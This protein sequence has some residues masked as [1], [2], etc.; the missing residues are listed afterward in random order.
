MVGKCRTRVG[1]SLSQIAEVDAALSARAHRLRVQQ[2]RRGTHRRAR[3]HNAQD[4]HNGD[5]PWLRARRRHRPRQDPARMGTT[6]LRVHDPGH[7]RVRLPGATGLHGTSRDV[8]VRIRPPDRRQRHFG[9][10]SPHR[11]IASSPSRS[12]AGEAPHSSDIPEYWPTLRLSPHAPR[13]AS[14]ETPLAELVEGAR[15]TTSRAARGAAAGRRL[16]TDGVDALWRPREAH[17][18]R[19]SGGYARAERVRQRKT[20]NHASDWKATS[21]GTGLQSRRVQLRRRT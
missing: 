16:D 19:A 1:R 20:R 3:P 12:A 6:E 8:S 9:P 7:Q 10:T 2:R 17:I 14:A 18:A 5:V 13:V 4:A 21:D 11:R 15:Q